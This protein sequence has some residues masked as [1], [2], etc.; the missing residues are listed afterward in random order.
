MSS[1]AWQT[2][3]PRQTLKEADVALRTY[4]AEKMSVL[5]QCQVNV[6]VNGQ[7]KQLVLTIVEG[8][9]PS[10]LGRDWLK[11]LQLDWQQIAKVD[12]TNKLEKLLQDYEEIF[13]EGTG[14]VN[15][16]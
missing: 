11:H 1:T 4:T 2:L 15:S 13:K 8:G 3:F 10:L 14:T 7:K 16:Y 9:G 12:S 6:K 5:G